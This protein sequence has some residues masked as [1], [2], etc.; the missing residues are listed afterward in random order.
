M[1]N[2]KYSASCTWEPL[3]GVGYHHAGVREEGVHARGQH[4][5]HGGGQGVHPPRQ[6]ERVPELQL[7]GRRRGRGD[8]GREAR[9]GRGRQRHGRHRG[10]R[11]AAGGECY[12]SRRTSLSTAVSP[13]AARGGGL[14]PV[15][16]VEAC[17][18]LT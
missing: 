1:F 12:L 18:G 17:S 13:G 7:R 14:V 6:P 15:E 11:L 2:S 9:H 4:P 8:V 10:L 3:E 16:S 5:R